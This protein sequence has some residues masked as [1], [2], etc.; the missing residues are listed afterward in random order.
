MAI[1]TREERAGLAE[2][3]LQARQFGPEVTM[4]AIFAEMAA[5][6]SE[7]V[8]YA[9][10]AKCSGL[11]LIPGGALPPTP[12]DFCGEPKRFIWLSDIMRGYAL[13][14]ERANRG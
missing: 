11:K 6:P 2:M 13:L 14:L 8:K 3:W 5:R 1:Y 4:K 7:G 9:V 10:C 12:C